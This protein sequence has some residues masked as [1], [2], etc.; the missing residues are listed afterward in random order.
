MCL[1][2][3]IVSYIWLMLNDHSWL[4]V[5]RENTCNNIFFKMLF[6]LWKILLKCFISLYN[7]SYLKIC[8]FRYT[9]CYWHV[10]VA[11][12]YFSLYNFFFNIS[13]STESLTSIFFT[14]STCF[15]LWSPVFFSNLL[16]H[17]HFQSLSRSIG[18]ICHLGPHVSTLHISIPL[19]H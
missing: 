11:S 4:Q 5:F 12:L 15:W 14:Y 10:N 17:L 9:E 7:Y 16:T 2:K 6:Y 13:I 3:Y 18:I 8:I 1:S 19:P